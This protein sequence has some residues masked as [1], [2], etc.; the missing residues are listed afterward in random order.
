MDAMI[1]DLRALESVSADVSGSGGGT[2][3]KLGGS[4]AG[5]SDASNTLR[6]DAK[7]RLVEVLGEGEIV[8]L[9]NG[10]QSI[11]FDQTSLQNADGTFNFVGVTWQ[12]RHGEPE[13]PP[14]IGMASSETTYSVG[15]EIKKSQEPPVRTIADENATSVRVVCQI[16]TLVVQNP[17][18]GSLL[19]NDLDYMIEIRPNGGQWT[20]V[21]RE[22]LLQ[23]KTTSPY[24]RAS[25][26]S[27][28]PGGHPYSLRVR[29]ESPD[30]T[31][32]YMQAG[33]I[34]ES[35]TTIVEGQFT[36]PHTALVALELDAQQF[37][38]SIPSRYY[39]VKGL[40]IQVPSNY[41][42]EARTYTGFWDG[43]FKRAWTNNPAWIFYDL[44]TND[45]YGLGEFID[46]TKIDK[47][48]LY[49]IGGYCDELVADGKGGQEPRYTFNGV[50]NSR[51][52]AYKVLQQIT[53][54]FRGM[55]FWSVGQVFAVADKP[56]DPVK[57][58]A[59][60]NVIGGQFKYSRTAKK[61][62]N[63]VAMVSWND[64]ED[65]Y[66]NAIEVVQHDEGLDKFGWRQTDIQAVG[67][68]SRGLAHRIGAWTLDTDYTAT[69]SVEFEMGLDALA[70][71]P[72]R[73]GHI[74]AI[75]DPRKAQTRI[76]GRVIS[77]SPSR[78]NL[79]KAFEPTATATYKIS[80]VNKAG[81]IETRG[82]IGWEQGNVTAVLDAELEGEIAPGA[83]WAISG[84]DVAPRQYRVLSVTEPK[85][86]TFK[87]AALFHDPTKYA[88]IEQ[89]VFL[90]PPSYVRPSTKL[91]PP[92]NLK[93]TETQTFRDGLPHIEV[94][95]SWTP[96]SDWMSNAYS[97]LL[98][99]PDGDVDMGVTSNPSITLP[100][101]KAGDWTAYVTGQGQGKRSAPASLAFTVAGWEGQPG[102]AVANLRVRGQ[103]AGDG[104][105]AGKDLVL[106]WDVTWPDAVIP[107]AIDFV[108][109]ILDVD[110]QELVSDWVAPGGTF[111]Y[112][113]DANAA[114]GGPRRKF[115]VQVRAR[116]VLGR[117]SAPAT[118]VCENA[119]PDVISPSITTTTESLFVS[120]DR[121]ADPDFAG[122]LVWLEQ[123]SGF[124]PAATKPAYDGN[125]TLVSFKVTPETFYFVRVA[126]YDQFGKQGLNVGP[127]QKVWVSNRIIDTDVPGAPTGL[128][129]ETAA[130]TAIDGTL[131]AVVRASWD[132]SGSENLAG[133]EVEVSVEGGTWVRERVTDPAWEKHGLAPGQT[134]AVRVRAYNG[135]DTVGTWSDPVAI[136]A[137][138]NDIAPDPVTGLAVAAAFE[139]AVLSWV[140]PAQADLAYVEL[141]AAA[142]QNAQRA[143]LGRAV[144]GAQTFIDKTLPV[145]QTRFYWAR[146]VNTS[147]TQSEVFAGPVQ[148]VSP[149]ITKEQIA[150]QILDQTSFADGLTAIGVVDTLP[151]LADY[152]GP[153]VL[154]LKTDGKL[155][156][157]EDGKWEPV[158][159]NTTAGGIVG[160]IKGTQIEDGAIS[161]EKMAAN[162]IDADRLVANSITAGL[163]AAGAIKAEALAAGA[164]TADK[165]AVGLSSGNLL[166]N[167]DFLGGVS[168]FALHGASDGVAPA[169]TASTTFAPPGMGA[170]LVARADTPAAGAYA[171]L[172]LERRLP[173]GWDE[174]YP[175]APGQRYELSAYASITRAQAQ[176][177]LLFLDA[178]RQPLAA[179]SGD[180][181]A[182]APG[183]GP[184][185]TMARLGVFGTA[186]AGAA[187]VVPVQ[188]AIW[189]G[190]AAPQVAW[191]GLYLAKALANQTAFAPWVANSS[192]VIDGGSI[193]TNSLSANRIVA[194]SITADQVKA[195]TITG[196]KIAAGT[197]TGDNIKA[198]SIQ[199]DRIRI[200]GEVTLSSWLGGP[201]ATQIDGGHIAANSIA[202][203]TLKIGARGL[204]TV[205]LD[206]SADKEEAT[207]SWSAGTILFTG[208]D[209]VA[210]AAAVAAGSVQTGGKHA[211]A[212]WSRAKQNVVQVALDSASAILADPDAV[213][214]CS[215]DGFA[216]LNPVYGG[217]IIDGSRINTG[218]ITAD[219]IKAGAIQAA[220]IA[221]GAITAEKIAAGEVTADKLG[222][223]TITADLIF[224]GSA[225]FQLDARNRLMRIVANNGVEQVSIGNVGVFEGDGKTEIY[226]MEVRD[227]NGQAVLKITDDETSLD[228]S[229]IRKATI[230]GASIKDASIQAAQIGD[231]AITNAKIGD[232]QVNTVKIAGKAVS[233]TVANADPGKVTTVPIA[234]RELTS[235]FQIL[236]YRK[237]DGGT[238]HPQ[239]ASTGALTVDYSADGGQTWTVLRGVVNSFS[240]LYSVSAGG[241][242]QF[243][244]PTVLVF[245]WEP[246]Q[247]GNLILRVTD[248][249]GEPNVGDVYL[250][251][252]ELTR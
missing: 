116:D 36:Y 58:L 171:D 190:Q 43:T 175:V 55:A 121:P 211:F 205:G 89:N 112:G 35:Y 182:A 142:A 201:D 49:E 13:Q 24:E 17:K 123:A 29:R 114:D 28:P 147:G 135:S 141:F 233:Q 68:T 207:L 136:V 165:I 71:D 229:Y 125:S 177:I 65:F 192:T 109:R 154:L 244:T 88:R 12:E 188:R 45:R 163:I 14:L 21:H 106:D 130:E 140:D 30:P 166:F 8:G 224:L 212:W 236:A 155:Y 92:V 238:P 180:V 80:V 241:S 122:V 1:E 25:V 168:G 198:G 196:D 127:E 64:P 40:I 149:V 240:Y 83:M 138:V 51:D 120:F 133:Y 46:E 129:L 128:K 148:A 173:A 5:K 215:Y 232:L 26:V 189:T 76:G 73:P 158:V 134:Y 195:G 57:L 108:V 176:V 124:D 4:S 156:Q 94:L 33:L 146:T 250:S 117:E 203:N 157:I 86:N 227:K 219:Q 101:L 209:G 119:A 220:N 110:T 56:A 3:A 97:V 143:S 213:L 228:G 210:V 104:A 44:L 132:K 153:L 103:D 206:F 222:A 187:F 70:A 102:P 75:A 54:A 81:V 95:L 118:L 183:V 150:G 172:V 63:T 161:T 90:A 197:I 47:F 181:H 93:A 234:A 144:A 59:P 217:T 99:G 137:A 178:S 204:Q 248:S 221:A 107:Y 194:G 31:V 27:L 170:A 85:K 231:A 96:A 223:G 111:T 78:L 225:N 61:T 218:S 139:T 32:D 230:D 53:A 214:L 34:W 184:L 208:D 202:A 19:P 115:W 98:S 15:V 52:E 159:G 11:F 251:V 152:D 77:H 39:D 164:I 252:T 9:V 66:R 74:V 22:L 79:D 246:K 18:N 50:I 191:T 10:A 84:T 145:G 249:N 167:A 237:G 185:E 38:G 37:G 200:G 169:I 235:I 20:E 247:I 160:Q 62:R 162:S 100:D 69:E 199:A 239:N 60:A 7:A 216:G 242:F 126:A 6:S 23:Q 67:C 186:P 193:A 105:F 131:T 16:P 48:G 179:A 82:V 41:D 243:M 151:A 42:P 226:G 91:L 174:A 72:L 87:V 2:S 245:S 113:L